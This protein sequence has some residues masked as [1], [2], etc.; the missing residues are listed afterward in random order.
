MLRGLERRAIYAPSRYPIGNWSP[1]DLA[2]EDTWLA[3]TDGVRL[4]GWYCRC[5]DSI[6]NW[7]RGPRPVVLYAHGNAGNLS[8]RAEH[9]RDWQRGAGVDMFLFDYRGYG[10]SEGEPGERELYLDSRAAYH[11][12]VHERGVEPTRIILLG[13]SLGGAVA[14]ELGLHAEHRCLI[15]EA[16]FTSLVDVAQRLYPWIPVRMVLRTRFPSA[17]RIGRYRQPVLIIH[18]TRDS[19][20]PV[21]QG[22]ELFRRANEPKR[23]YEIPGADHNNCIAVAGRKYFDVVGNFLREVFNG[24]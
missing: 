15:L 13:S 12:L 9:V 1:R 6:P 5:P 24:A 4:H 22:R 18:G 21:E 14:L 11:W 7:S 19:L 2:Y 20:I 23:L 17:D 8:D 3:T 16:T 10:R